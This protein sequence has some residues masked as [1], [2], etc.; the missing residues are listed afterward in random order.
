M[1]DY[2]FWQ[3]N[4]KNSGAKS[5][6]EEGSESL[7]RMIR[8]ETVH[9]WEKAKR[10]WAKEDKEAAARADQVSKSLKQVCDFILGALIVAF[11]VLASLAVAGPIFLA[12]I[13]IGAF[14]WNFFN[15][16]ED[17]Q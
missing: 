10:W 13:I 4:S 15:D 3:W 12:G 14:V 8:G 1:E 16:K 7:G 6:F 17:N 5:R 2:K 9:Y 11:A